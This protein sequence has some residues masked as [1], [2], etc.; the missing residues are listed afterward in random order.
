MSAPSLLHKLSGRR[1]ETMVDD[2]VALVVRGFDVG[3]R[4]G[5]LPSQFAGCDA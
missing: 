2:A 1:G 4:I 5:R 3:T